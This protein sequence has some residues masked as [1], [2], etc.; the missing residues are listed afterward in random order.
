M[1]VSISMKAGGSSSSCWVLHGETAQYQLECWHRLSPAGTSME[2]CSAWGGAKWHNSSM[3]QLPAMECVPFQRPQQHLAMHNSS[4]EHIQPD[5]SDGSFLLY[6][7]TTTTT[8]ITF[9]LS[10]PGGAKLLSDTDF[11][12]ILQVTWY[13]AEVQY[14]LF[15]LHRYKNHHDLLKNIEVGFLLTCQYIHLFLKAVPYKTQ[16]RYI[17]QGNL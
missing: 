12:I 4:W 13:K 17:P 9:S 3:L 6:H 2:L 14:Y 7:E 5:I 15:I 1:L 8:T 11:S 10:Y 16:G